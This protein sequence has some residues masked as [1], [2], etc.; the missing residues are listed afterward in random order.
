MVSCDR[1]GEAQGRSSVLQC[2]QP[3]ELW[4][5]Q[6]DASGDSR[7]A[8]HA[9]GIWSAYLYDF[10]AHRPAGRWIGWRQQSTHDRLSGTVGGLNFVNPTRVVG[11]RE[12]WGFR[13][14]RN[15]L[16]IPSAAIGMHCPSSA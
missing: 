15:T 6:Y 8:F 11:V 5:S 2:V 4:A 1:A 10:T 13:S 9:D 7:K 14:R 16:N 12:G 3:S